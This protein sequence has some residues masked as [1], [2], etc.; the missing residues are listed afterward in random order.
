[1]GCLFGFFFICNLNDN[2]F[3]FLS[4]C[5]RNRTILDS[6]RD[7]NAVFGMVTH[8][9]EKLEDDVVDET[10]ESALQTASRP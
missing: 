8:W 1:M 6:G 2:L 3:A 7:W 9:S 5:V 4:V 10:L